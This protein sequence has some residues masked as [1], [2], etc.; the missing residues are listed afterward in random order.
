VID[1]DVKVTNTGDVTRTNVVV[2]D[3]LTGG[4]LGT[5]A[6]LAVG[7]SKDFL[8]SYTIQQGDVNND[9]NPAASGDIINTATATSDQAG[10]KTSS[11]RTPIDYVPGLAISKT[12]TS[13]VDSNG[14]HLTDSGD[15][16]DYD[17]KVTNTGDVTLTNVVVTD[18]LTGGTLGTLASLAVGASKDC[19]T[20]YTIQQGDVNN[21]GNPAASGD[22]I[23]T[24]TATSDQARPKTSSART[25]I[26]YAPGIAGHERRPAFRT[27]QSFSAV[28]TTA[29]K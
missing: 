4:M 9:G 22:I 14:D 28:S 26:D 21:D 20:S 13:V 10:P 17:V 5:L 8:T 29:G 6:S 11:A 25:P 19:L 2:T 16:I 24:A 18:P 1:Y 12:V 27:T 7:A 23:N 3:P 15:A